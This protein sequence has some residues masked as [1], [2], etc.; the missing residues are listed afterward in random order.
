MSIT[1]V[2]IL[3]DI[4]TR[5]LMMGGRVNANDEYGSAQE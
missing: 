2:V 1:L 3:D 4:T 5:M